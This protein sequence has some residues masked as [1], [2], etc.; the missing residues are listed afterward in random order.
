MQAQLVGLLEGLA[1]APRVS[2]ALLA[3]TDSS[4]RQGG[5]ATV[6]LGV[7]CVGA[8]KGQV[9]GDRI[10]L[11]VDDDPTTFSFPATDLELGTYSMIV[12]CGQGL[13]ARSRLLIFR[14]NGA[15]RGGANS[16][17]VVTSVGLGS[18]VVLFGLPALAPPAGIV[19]RRRRTG[20]S[21]MPPGS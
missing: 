13:M 7:G 19:A 17:V 21:P 8:T 6:D 20:R 3:L 5:R 9:G 2:G 10:V 11:D 12:D 14:Q 4:S 16:V 15:Q 1:V 18:T